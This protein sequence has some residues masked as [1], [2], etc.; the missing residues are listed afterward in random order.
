MSRLAPATKKQ[1]AAKIGGGAAGSTIIGGILGG[2]DGAAKGPR[3]A[4]QPGPASCSRRAARKC[5]CRRGPTS[6]FALRRLSACECRPGKGENRVQFFCARS[7]LEPSSRPLG[8][9]ADAAAEPPSSAEAAPTH[10]P[11]RTL[12]V[13]R[14][15]AFIEVVLCSGLPTQILVFSALTGLGLQCRTADGGWSPPFLVAM[16]LTDMVLIIGLVYLFLRAHHEPLRQFIVGHR[17]PLREVALGLA[18]IPA[19]LVLVVLVLTSILALKPELHNVTVNPFERMLQT[20]RD[21]AVFA[22]V[23]MFAGGLREEVQRAFIIEAST[24]ISAAVSPG[25]WATAASSE[26]ATWIRATRRRLR[27]VCSAPRGDSSTGRGAASSRRSSA[28]PASISSSW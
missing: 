1:D 25:F 27:Q 26:S 22:F 17:R 5:G 2:G 10:G 8:V 4:A 12:P 21:A 9:P 13:E 11:R 23:V 19:A 28:T 16:S 18:L 15:G 6:A 24:S 14:I 20:P 3:S 7:G